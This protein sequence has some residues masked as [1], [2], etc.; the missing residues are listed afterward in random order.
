LGIPNWALVALAILTS[1]LLLTHRLIEISSAVAGVFGPI[2]HRVRDRARARSAAQL[3]LSAESVAE[4][5]DSVKA[6]VTALER[7]RAIHEAFV[8]YDAEWHRRAKVLLVGVKLPRHL[9]FYEFEQ[10]WRDG[11]RPS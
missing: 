9:N 1:L 11:W 10:K 8:A 7:R 6:R 5:I 3:T 4:E 2:G